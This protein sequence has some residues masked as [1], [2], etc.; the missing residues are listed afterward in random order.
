M[1]ILYMPM[2]YK[3]TFRFG[4]LHNVEK[5]SNLHKSI[6]HHFTNVANIEILC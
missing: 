6:C 4:I 5:L 3:Q 2:L 1:L